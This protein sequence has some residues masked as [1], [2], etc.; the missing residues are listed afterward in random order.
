MT[1]SVLKGA[2]D[3]EGQLG[4]EL[5]PEQGLDSVPVSARPSSSIASTR[6]FTSMKRAAITDARVRATR[7]S[8]VPSANGMILEIRFR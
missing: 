6:D 2:L 3:V 5:G 7:G 1:R 8:A 4:L